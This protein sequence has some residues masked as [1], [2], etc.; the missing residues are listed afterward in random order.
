MCVNTHPQ[1]LL[2]ATLTQVH[3]CDGHAANTFLAVSYVSCTKIQSQKKKHR[4][5]ILLLLPLLSR[6]LTLFYYNGQT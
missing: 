2:Y 6:T 3:R 1:Y 5:I 4:N